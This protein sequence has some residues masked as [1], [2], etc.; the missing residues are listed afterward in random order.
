MLAHI[1]CTVCLWNY[2]YFVFFNSY[3]SSWVLFSLVP[4]FLCF[5]CFLRLFLPVSCILFPAE[6]TFLISTVCTWAFYGSWHS[7]HARYG[8]CGCCVSVHTPHIVDFASIIYHLSY[9]PRYPYVYIFA[10]TVPVYA[11]HICLHKLADLFCKCQLQL[12]IEIQPLIPTT[13]MHC[14]SIFVTWLAYLY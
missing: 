4:N 6:S 9:I 14:C 10:S 8:V 1:I 11:F 3:L 7:Y 13:M 2:S 5:I 12:S